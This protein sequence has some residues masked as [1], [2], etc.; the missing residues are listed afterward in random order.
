MIQHYSGPSALLINQDEVIPEP[1]GY[2]AAWIGFLGQREIT[3]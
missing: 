1:Y 3:G 2:P